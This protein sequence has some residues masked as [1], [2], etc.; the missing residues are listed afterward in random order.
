MTERTREE[1][2]ALLAIAEP[3]DLVTLADQVIADV[4]EPAILAA[5]QVGAI[6]TQ[7][8]E[9]IGRERFFL[10][11]VLSCRA[12]VEL[13]GARGWAMRLGEDRAAVLAAAILDAAA[14]IDAATAGAVDA[15]CTQVEINRD[16]RER[17]EW[18]QLQ[19]TIVEF[20]EL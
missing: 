8:R 13:A 1:R 3:A 4:G 17:A 6:A 14:Q 18:A 7:I 10:G 2:C 12:E 16:E 5:P 20:E 9:P 15:L 19:P 11:D